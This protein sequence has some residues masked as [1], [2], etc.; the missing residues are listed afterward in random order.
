[1]SDAEGE[2]GAR[3]CSARALLVFVDE[4]SREQSCIISNALNAPVKLESTAS[5]APLRSVGT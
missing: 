2:A 5:T 3:S 4:S 1:V